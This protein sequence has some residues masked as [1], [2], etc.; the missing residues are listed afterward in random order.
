MAH[1]IVAR[2]D[3]FSEFSIFLIKLALHTW[4]VVWASEEK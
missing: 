1:S 2:E 3:N 4:C